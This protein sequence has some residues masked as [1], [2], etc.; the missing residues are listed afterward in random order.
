MK[1]LLVVL[2]LI[3]GLFTQAQDITG[4]WHGLLKFPGG[5][6]KMDFHITKSG[7]GYTA[8]MDVPE[9]NANGIPV[10]TT[11]FENNTLAMAIPAANISYKGTIEGKIIKG[12]YI[13]N[14]NTLPL[15]LSREAVTI[16]AAKRPQDPVK[17]YPYY[18]E[19]VTIK[20][21][22]AGVTLAGTLT[23][24]KQGG[25]NYP[26]V[27]L[28]T[29]SGAQDRNEEI[30][31]HK[32]FLVIAD[33]LT[34]QGIAVLRYDDRGTAKS[35]GDFDN[36]TTQDFATDADAAFAYLKT[37]KEINSKK[38]G[39]IGHSEGGVIAPIVASNNTDVAFIVMLA[40][41]AI[42][43]DELMMLQ[44][45]LIGKANGMPEEELTKLGNINRAIYTLIKEEQDTQILKSRLKANFNK[46]MKPLLISKGIPD[47]QVNSYIDA[48]ISDITSP[49]YA[50]FIRY[51][52]YPTLEKVK[53]PILALNGEKDVQVAPKANLDAIKRAALK[54]GNKKVTT[55][56][57]PGL[58]HLF[59]ASTTGAPT[60]YGE[61]EETFSPTALKIMGD[62]ISQQVK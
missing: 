45:Y 23:L 54:S 32:S 42:P 48:Q 37:R 40:G 21:D 27:I 46:D 61:I 12:T 57:I 62:W 13:Q 39:L 51:N 30:L 34:R 50:A 58:N 11:V 52:P 28:I 44:N 31:G 20:N 9:Q 26:A 17:P 15:D 55:Q 3:T 59:Q 24:P 33:Y 8:T 25:T 5:Q 16:V 19:E 53:C 49:W 1:K 35:T 14:G 2:T 6:F 47:A 22:K 7:T 4:D 10:G 36:A 29:G 41:T 18:E 56:E 60:E 43:G 38:I